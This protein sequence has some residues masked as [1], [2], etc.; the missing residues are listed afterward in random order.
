MPIQRI[1]FIGLGAMG[2]GLAGNLVAAGYEV[3]VWDQSAAALEAFTSRHDAQ[4][5]SSPAKLGAGVDVAITMVPD[6]PDVRAVAV[7]PSGLIDSGNDSLIYID[8]STIDPTTSR[9]VGA[10]L[11]QKNIRMLDSP[12][13]RG[14]PEA[15][16]G[17]V[18]FMV[19][20]D[21]DLLQEVRPV[22]EVMSS[23]ILHVGPLGAGT[24]IKL[25]NNFLGG[26]II[27]TIAEALALGVKSGLSVE[28]IIDLSD[29]TGTSNKILNMVLPSKAFVGDYSPG[30]ASRLAAKDQRL[31]LK[32]GEDLGVDLPVGE[33]VMARYADCEHA[34]PNEDYMGSVMR[35]VERQSE[36]KLR[37]KGK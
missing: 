20:G 6:A 32:L 36:T 25:V 16:A 33:A 4:I 29:R 7:G 8:M 17:T 10:A 1:G 30:F 11:A 5:A 9:E 22:L 27:A 23:E 14:V 3:H 2:R 19:G 28:Q 15:E 18:T 26:G 13:G 12:V 24:A 35:L 34:Y 21:A 31:A 37:F